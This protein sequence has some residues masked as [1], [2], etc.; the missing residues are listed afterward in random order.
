MEALNDPRNPGRPPFAVIRAWRDLAQAAVAEL[1]VA[2]AQ[3]ELAT[4]DTGL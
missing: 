3:D 2:T 4:L 1:L